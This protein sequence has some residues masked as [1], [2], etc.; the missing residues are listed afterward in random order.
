MRRKF[1]LT[2]TII[3]SAMIFSITAA[4]Q[5][6]FTV[7]LHGRQEVPA[8]NSPGSGNCMVTLNQ[9]ETQITVECSYRNLTSN[10]TGAH[11]HD[12]APVGVNG[13]IRFNF[14]YTGGTTG[15]IGPLL[16][17]TTPAQIVE[18]R[19]NKWY[20][21]IH[22]ANFPGGEIRGQ[23]KRANLSADYDGDGR[24]DV[25]VFRQ[26]AQTVYVLNSLDNR[27]TGVGL[28]TGTRDIF[29]NNGGDFDGDG[30]AD[31]ALLKFNADFTE[32][33]WVILQSATN[34]LRV[35]RW[36]DG[37]SDAIQPSDYDGDG[38]MDIA[39]F[40][41]QTG[42]WYIKESSTGNTRTVT[43][44]GR[45]NDVPCVGDFDGDGKADLCIT[46]AESGAGGPISWYILNS[47]TGQSQR[48][49]WG[50]P[51]TDRTFFFF[52][53]DFD[54]DGKQD[55]YVHRNVNGQRVFF[56]RRSSDGQMYTL[57][58]GAANWNIQ[59]GDYDGDGKTDPALRETI[60]GGNNGTTRWHI[61][62]SA[63]QTHRTVDFGEQ[64][65]PQGSSCC[66]TRPGGER[67]K[68]LEFGQYVGIENILDF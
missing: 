24:T 65:G 26:S 4:A 38:K 29:I 8:N 58:W 21:N 1:F 36:G 40:R 57:P 27:V 12:N 3:L 25:I 35:E 17:S 68:E 63:T 31:P 37:I 54:G 44:F 41:R 59:F 18:L 11:I 67:L 45:P 39:V 62:Q 20:V 22:T 15:T 23:V 47:S 55:I 19:S 28:G 51:V 42:I 10:V 49:E 61:F 2:L 13:P 52:P 14:N 56:V 9:T 30:R 34:S 7:S 66:D 50:N 53:I 60:P 64:L 46:R 6:K 32:M 5:Q 43:N 48:F 16:F 33:S